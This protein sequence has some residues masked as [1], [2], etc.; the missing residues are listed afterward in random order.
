MVYLPTFTIKIHY[1]NVGK[2]TIHG[3]YGY[4]LPRE[5]AGISSHWCFFQIQSRNRWVKNR[6]KHSSFFGPS[7]FLRCVFFCRRDNNVSSR[8]CCVFYVFFCCLPTPK[9][10]QV[11]DGKGKSSKIHHAFAL[12]DLFRTWLTYVNLPSCLILPIPWKSKDH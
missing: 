2:Y 12:F 4:T 11:K 10:L 3:S 6:V 5:S 1:I 9:D 7:W 8:S